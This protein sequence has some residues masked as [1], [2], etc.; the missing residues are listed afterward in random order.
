MNRPIY[1]DEDPQ[2]RIAQNSFKDEIEQI[3]GYRLEELPRKYGAD[4]FAW[5]S[6]NIIAMYEVKCRDHTVNKYADLM[7]S[8]HKI[9]MSLI[10]AKFL[11]LPLFLWIK[12]TDRIGYIEIRQDMPRSLGMGTNGQRSD[13][14]DR[15]PM[16][17]YEINKFHLL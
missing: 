9:V 3:T 15:E 4:Y 14:A 17:Y 6:S 10:F 1:E 11:N 2:W 7:I 8:V 12:W 16:L 13:P 5:K